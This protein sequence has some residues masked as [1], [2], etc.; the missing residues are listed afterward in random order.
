M[1]SVFLAMAPIR[2]M[3]FPIK[4]FPQVLDVLFGHIHGILKDNSS[5]TV[6]ASFKF[7]SLTVVASYNFEMKNRSRF[8]ANQGLR[9]NEPMVSS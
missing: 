3:Y 5:L 6:V 8:R 7:V 4:I 9:I 1:V 2:D